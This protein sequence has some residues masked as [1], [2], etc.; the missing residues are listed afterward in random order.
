[1]GAKPGGGRVDRRYGR[2]QRRPYRRNRA[3]LKEAAAV[4][5]PRG[6]LIPE[7]SRPRNSASSQPFRFEVSHSI[8][9]A[10]SLDHRV[11]KQPLARY[12]ERRAGEPM[13]AERVSVRRCDV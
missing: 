5:A 10:L 2:R 4:K 11:R 3:L 9:G 12:G 13:P 7:Q 6:V 1:M 8:E